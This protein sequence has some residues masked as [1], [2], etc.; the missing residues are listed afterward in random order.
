METRCPWEGFPWTRRLSANGSPP[1]RARLRLA[2]A[3]SR[4]WA[5]ETSAARREGLFP[6]RQ[7]ESPNIRKSLVINA[8]LK[9]LRLCFPRRFPHFEQEYAEP[10]KPFADY[11]R[12]RPQAPRL[13]W[14]GGRK[15]PLRFLFDPSASRPR[16]VVTAAWHPAR[17]GSPSATPED[18]LVGHIGSAPARRRDAFHGFVSTRALLLSPR[19][20]SSPVALPLRATRRFERPETGSSHPLAS[21]RRVDPP[22]TQ[23]DYI[24]SSG[25][26]MQ[27]LPTLG[28][29]MSWSMWVARRA[30]RTV[31]TGTRLRCTGQNV[32]AIIRCASSRSAAVNGNR[33]RISS[34][35]W[36][37]ANQMAI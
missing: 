13:R 24:P 2:S 4:I 34:G 32:P 37:C 19:S 6:L 31:E 16:P 7:G 27:W 20:F 9:L 26:P 25:L 30:S 28:C 29:S 33:S 11:D 14:G 35:A 8:L 3:S 23:P 22:L 1:D 5:S 17:R 36:P 15:E 21:R 18:S 12:S 10:F